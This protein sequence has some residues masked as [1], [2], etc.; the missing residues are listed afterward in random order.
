MKKNGSVTWDQITTDSTVVSN[1]PKSISSHTNSWKRKILNQYNAGD[2]TAMKRWEKEFQRETIQWCQIVSI[3]N[4]E[5]WQQEIL[6]RH[7]SGSEDAAMRNYDATRQEAIEWNEMISSQTILPELETDTYKVLTSFLGFIP[8]PYIIIPHITYI[9]EKIRLLKAGDLPED[10]WITQ[11]EN[12]CKRMRNKYVQKHSMKDYE[13]KAYEYYNRLP[14]EYRSVVRHRFTRFLGYEPDIK[15]SVRVEI[16]MI[17]TIIRDHKK[18]PDTLT[19]ADF[20]CFLVIKYRE[21]LLAKG[22][23]AAEFSDLPI[24][25][26]KERNSYKEIF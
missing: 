20:Q 1:K 15:T 26:I 22:K 9:R 18:W 3:P 8:E 10:I 7:Y 13:P 16:S 25:K 4:K 19:P 12:I 5:P 24:I 11:I 21:A 23:I 14:I 2:T 17:D 6:D